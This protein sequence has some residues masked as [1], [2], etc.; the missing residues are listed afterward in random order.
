MLSPLWETACSVV[1]VGSVVL[2]PSCAA[3]VAGH[4]AAMPGCRQRQTV[5]E[6]GGQACTIGVARET[7]RAADEI[8]NTNTN[9]NPKGTQ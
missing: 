6:H 9:T 7:L 8:T 3:T 4:D 2:C 5:F 1:V